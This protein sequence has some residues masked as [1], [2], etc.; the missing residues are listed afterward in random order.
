MVIKVGQ[1][2][3][4]DII[5]RAGAVT[6]LDGN[7]ADTDHLSIRLDADHHGVEGQH[8]LRVT[9]PWRGTAWNQHAVIEASAK[10]QT[11]GVRAE[12]KIR[13][14]EVKPNDS[15]FFQRVEYDELDGRK[16]SQF[17]A[18]VIT[19]NTL[20]PLNRMIFGSGAT[21]EEAKREFDR[22]LT[23]DPKAQQRL[24]SILV[25]EA[26]FRALQQLF[27]DNKLLLAPQR[28]VAEIHQEIDK[29]KFDSAPAIYRSLVR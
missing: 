4:V 1:C 21:K 22:R 24:A 28:E 7:G 15:G 26:C 18:G 12:A 8:I 14:D 17:A 9:I 20:D 29:L 2:I 16:P 23:G 3:R 6:L 27:D 11:G 25:E 13:I 10:A 5:K 19:V